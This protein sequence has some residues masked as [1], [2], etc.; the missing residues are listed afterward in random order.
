MDYMKENFK[1]ITN[2]VSEIKHQKINQLSTGQKRI[3]EI[4]KMECI[5]GISN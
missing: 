3:V 4:F 2:I 1:I 5:H